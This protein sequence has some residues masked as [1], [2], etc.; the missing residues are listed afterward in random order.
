MVISVVRGGIFLMRLIEINKKINCKKMSEQSRSPCPVLNALAN[1][2]IL[3]NDGRNI[4]AN[5]LESSLER[6]GVSSSIASRL[7]SSAMDIGSIGKNGERVLN[8]NDL[9]KHGA[10]EHDLSLSRDD[11]YFGNNIDFSKKQFNKIHQ[12]IDSNDNLTFDNLARWRNSLMA[13]T[14]NPERTFNFRENV[15]AST[16]AALLYLLLKDSNN[17]IPFEKLKKLFIEERLDE[18]D[19]NPI[20]MFSL[21]LTVAQLKWRQLFVGTMVIENKLDMS[22]IGYRATENYYTPI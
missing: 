16:E 22:E 17:N 9:S 6:I 15:I 2:C 20:S 4:T 3:P 13:D 8:L 18:N 21:V 19:V 7:S 11:I 1:S 5:M 14:S 12:F 10:I